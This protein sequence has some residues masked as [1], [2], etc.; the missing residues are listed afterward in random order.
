MFNGNVYVLEE[1]VQS[2]P[3]KKRTVFSMG[4]WKQK[5]LITEMKL[6][7][8]WV[9]LNKQDR[10]YKIVNSYEDSEC[11]EEEITLRGETK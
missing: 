2:D 3:T 6:A 5:Y 10:R 1:F 8:A 7:E 9:N 4:V 11:V